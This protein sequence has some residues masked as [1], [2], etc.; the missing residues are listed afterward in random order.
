MP[1][2]CLKFST[3]PALA[4]NWFAVMPISSASARALCRRHRSE[5][6]FPFLHTSFVHSSSRS[7]R[8]G[9]F[10][11][12]FP[13]SVSLH[14]VELRQLP[15]LRIVG[16]QSSISVEKAV[17]VPILQNFADATAIHTESRR[18]F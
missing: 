2:R 9:N 11:G 15:M 14:R 16:L 10:P 1:T 6:G 5:I 3:H 13:M 17:L 7:S 12:L 8:S 4:L 18:D